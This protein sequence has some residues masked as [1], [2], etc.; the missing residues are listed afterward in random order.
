MCKWGL[1]QY[2]SS[3]VH[4]QALVSADGILPGSISKLRLLVI[5]LASVP[6]R[7]LVNSPTAQS[8]KRCA[9]PINDITKYNRLNQPTISTK[10]KLWICI[11]F[12]LLILMLTNPSNSD[13]NDYLS[14]KNFGH[15]ENSGRV[16]YFLL[17]SVYGFNEEVS[18]GDNSGSYNIVRHTYIGIFKNFLEN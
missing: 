14:T 13:F 3:A 15:V 8:L 7:Q 5:N 17:F 12:L 18:T 4:I 10:K 6:G 2:Q 1:T 9:S 11:F 16:G